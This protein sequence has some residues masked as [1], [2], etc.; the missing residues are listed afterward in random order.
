MEELSR[1]EIASDLLD[2]A[3]A[4]S[5]DNGG[6]QIETIYKFLVSSKDDA[7]G[8]DESLC[9]HHNL[10]KKLLKVY[11]KDS[12]LIVLLDSYEYLRYLDVT[13]SISDEELQILTELDSLN[14]T[15]TDIYD[16]FYNVANKEKI[17]TL[18]VRYYEYIGKGND[19]TK[20]CRDY[21]FDNQTAF[22]NA[23]T[24]YVGNVEAMDFMCAIFD[25]L[26]EKY[27]SQINAVVTGEEEPELDDEEFDDEEMPEEYL[28]DPD[29]FDEEGYQAAIDEMFDEHEEAV[30]QI[31]VNFKTELFDKIISWLEDYFDD[32]FE[33][34]NFIG[35]FISY[36]YRTILDNK[37]NGR[38]FKE[39]ESLLKLL[40]NPDANFG[41]LVETFYDNSEFV[42][43]SLDI[44]TKRYYKSH[45]D[46]LTM[47]DV[48]TDVAEN[49]QIAMLDE[50]YPYK[51]EVLDAKL[52]SSPLYEMYD[53]VFMKYK[54]DYPGDYLERLYS[55][56]MDDTS[57]E[58]VFYEL[59]IE[60][61]L[62]YHR[63]MMI[64]YFT[65]RF[66]EMI[67]IKRLGVEKEE[68]FA[69]VDLEIEK[70]SLV[71]IIKNFSKNGIQILKGY[72]FILSQTES[73]LKNHIR[74]LDKK[75]ELKRLLQIDPLIIG[76]ST[77][78]RA[79]NDTE[80]YRYI[81]QNGIEKTVQYL[82]DLSKNDYE[83]AREHINELMVSIY[84]VAKEKE[85]LDTLEQMI[86]LV[87]EVESSDVE[88]YV[89][90]A[91]NDPT[92]L[93]QL[94]SKYYENEK[95]EEFPTKY[96]D[97]VVKFPKVKQKL[98]PFPNE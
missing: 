52:I 12:W 24:D 42:F 95:E 74:S 85:T 30:E 13:V 37:K 96:E 73:E 81:E 5:E 70:I 14:F 44:F 20:S 84:S 57:F 11:K 35:F 94:I 93:Y 64:R 69:Y 61:D 53:M 3:Y 6:K 89:R 56:L 79:F 26:D 54:L 55:L 31:M 90:T 25:Q 78:Y 4:L 1:I 40:E 9:S 2:E 29:E 10:T 21:N 39:E 15:F 88:L 16:Y 82:I 45:M 72:E 22:R 87:Y 86:A 63:I 97:R 8:I 51:K 41:L 28:E 33:S 19:F 92:V 58:P 77:Y 17:K 47:R 98:Y 60:G 49:N 76:E 75:V 43:V 38:L 71:G 66:V 36:V 83:S 67:Q 48:T 27:Q 34:D 59:D 80:L 91:L 46:V 7:S 62:T 65:R 23:L 50:H 18:L 32:K 68:M